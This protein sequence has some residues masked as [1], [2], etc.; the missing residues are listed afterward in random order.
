MWHVPHSKWKPSL[1]CWVNIQASFWQMF[2]T[3][4]TGFSVQSMSENKKTC[5]VLGSSKASSCQQNLWWTEGKGTITASACLLSPIL[6]LAFRKQPIYL[7]HSF[8]SLAT[9]E[10]M[11]LKL[12][13][14]PA[15]RLKRTPFR[16][17]RGSLHTSISHCTWL[18]SA[19]LPW[20]QNNKKFSRCS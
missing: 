16:D 20:Q 8:N 4:K 13:D 5:P 19:G 12:I 11:F 6:V 2:S 18:A 1:A 7:H 9:L 14:V 15:M 17:N 3:K 10:A